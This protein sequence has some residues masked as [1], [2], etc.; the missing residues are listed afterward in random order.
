MLEFSYIGSGHGCHILPKRQR[1]SNPVTSN[2]GGHVVQS[3]AS[4]PLLVF[5]SLDFF[6]NCF[7]LEFFS[8]CSTALTSTGWVQMTITPGHCPPSKQC[9]CHW[10]P[11]T[12]N[13]WHYGATSN[14]V[15]PN[16][17]TSKNFTPNPYWQT[18]LRINLL[19]KTLLRV[20]LL[21][22]TLLRNHV[23]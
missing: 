7:R 21:R 14:D 11:A 3:T 16:H 6:S 22:T 12:S 1:G 4:C 5:R 13:I 9:S 2:W 20:T 15:T 19:R 23:S 10:I 18:L 17:F 8:F